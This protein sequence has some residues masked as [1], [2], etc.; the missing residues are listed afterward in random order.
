MLAPLPSLISGI[1]PPCFGISMGKTR[2]GA[3]A[4]MIGV[5]FATGGATA[6]CVVWYEL[7]DSTGCGVYTALNSR[8]VAE[9][10]SFG[11]TAGLTAT[12]VNAASYSFGVAATGVSVAVF[13]LLAAW[14]KV[15]LYSFSLIKPLSIRSFANRLLASSAVP[16]WFTA[17]ASW[18]VMMPLDCSSSMSGLLW[19][20]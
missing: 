19:G 18:G 8:A 5:S 9:C 20:C 7:D 11:L 14:V 15:A 17:A 3:T 4:G 1:M 6:V 10:S 2:K 12:G 13:S 16:A